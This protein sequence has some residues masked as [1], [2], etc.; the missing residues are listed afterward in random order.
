MPNE[1]GI[2]RF[3]FSAS[4]AGL[5]ASLTNPVKRVDAKGESVLQACGGYSAD[6]VGEFHIEEIVRVKSM[7]TQVSGIR[8]KAGAWETLATS[9]VEGVDILGI[10]KA[11]RIV[12]RVTQRFPFKGGDPTVSF[13]G[14]HFEGLTIAGKP[15]ELPSDNA[16]A[17]DGPSAEIP[18]ALASSHRDFA[19]CLKALSSKDDKIVERLRNYVPYLSNGGG[20][21]KPGAVRTV[22]GS[23]A[24]NYQFDADDCRRCGHV[25]FVPN[26]GVIVLAEFLVNGDSI[27]ITMLQ[28]DLGS[29]VEGQ[30]CLSSG[31]T[32]GSPMPPPSPNA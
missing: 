5:S 14:S 13:F 18:Q 28:A 11:D 31:R 1:N 24:S 21:D 22:V 6:K 19:E 4:A 3:S 15:I 8:S 10:V 16:V 12:A 25:I 7:S 2:G 20:S 17:G 27:S 26:F 29:P 32:G 9:T 23:L 30:V